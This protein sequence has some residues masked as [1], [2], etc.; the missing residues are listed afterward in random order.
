[1]MKIEYVPPITEIGAFS[2]SKPHTE[3]LEYCFDRVKPPE[4]RIKVFQYWALLLGKWIL[5]NQG[6]QQLI[7]MT[8][9]LVHSKAGCRIIVAHSQLTLL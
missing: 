6:S 5:E 9:K 4:E 1:M 7:R 3:Y 8:S 2:E